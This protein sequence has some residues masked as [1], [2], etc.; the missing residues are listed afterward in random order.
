MNYIEKI[1]DIGYSAA[2]FTEPSRVFNCLLHDLSIVK[3]HSYGLKERSLN[4]LFS[5]LKNRKQRVRL[6]NTYNELTEILLGVPQGS[7][8]CFRPLLC[9]IFSCYLFFVP[10]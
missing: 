10:P 6:N 3:L 5:Y 8:L 2:A 1:G 4:L 7:I 9:K